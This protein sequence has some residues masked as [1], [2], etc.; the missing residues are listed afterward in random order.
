MNSCNS[1]GV[2]S[3]DFGI[4]GSS[5]LSVPGDD[6]GLELLPR[7]VGEE[8]RF[9]EDERGRLEG[10]RDTVGD[11]GGLPAGDG[12]LLP[13]NTSWVGGMGVL[14]GRCAR[15]KGMTGNCL[16]GIG[17]EI[18]CETP[19]GMLSRGGCDGVLGPCSLSV[20]LKSSISSSSSIVGK[21]C[22]NSDTLPEPRGD[23]GVI[24]GESETEDTGDGGPKLE[25][26]MSVCGVG[27][28]GVD[29][30][31]IGVIT[32]VCSDSRLKGF[33]GIG[34]TGNDGSVAGGSEEDD[35]DD[36]SC[37]GVLV[38]FVAS[39]GTCFVEAKDSPAFCNEAI[40]PAIDLG[41]EGLR[42]RNLVRIVL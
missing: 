34:E 18:G 9:V 29:T 32:E 28:M 24:F 36:A 21:Y 14:D 26:G 40:L 31:C 11:S 3:V 35:E 22:W 2:H 20:T 4:F 42:Q 16:M 25:A 1:F 8:R 12:G 23:A 39:R 13:I 27:M 17:I 15:S 37:V 5:C 30:G 33:A 38:P 41:P 6:P 10:F 19:F 7:G